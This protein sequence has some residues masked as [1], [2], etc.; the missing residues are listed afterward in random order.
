MWDFFIFDFFFV[1]TKISAL[2]TALLP[3]RFSVVLY[4]IFVLNLVWVCLFCEK[5]EIKII[6]LAA[7]ISLIASQSDPF[8]FLL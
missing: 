3:L 4:G 5:K 1:E 7:L 6:A 8:Y 2:G